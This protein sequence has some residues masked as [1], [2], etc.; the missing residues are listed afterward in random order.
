MR[1]LLLPAA[2]RR[3]LTWV[4]L[5]AGFSVLALALFAPQLGIG[6]KENFLPY[7]LAGI[8]RRQFL[9]IGVF[10]I[11]AVPFFQVLAM[12]KL[13]LDRGIPFLRARL[14]FLGRNVSTAVIPSLARRKGARSGPAGAKYDLR[15][16][17]GADPLQ[18][19]GHCT[20][21]F[22]RR[23]SSSCFA[24]AAMLLFLL[25]IGLLPA[26]STEWRR[27]WLSEV[28]QQYGFVG[29]D[30]QRQAHVI[31]VVA[32]VVFSAISFLLSE[33]AFSA[34]QK[35]RFAPRLRAA[36]CIFLIAL[37]LIVYLFFVPSFIVGW[38]TGVAI[39]FLAIVIAAPRLPAATARH[40]AVAFVGAY[41]M[42]LIVPG[43]LVSP[44]P[45]MAA[46]PVS[47]AQFET[48]L[49]IL[50]M[51]GAAVAAGQNFFNELSI[52][53]GLLM[54]SIMS[55][56]ELKRHGLSIASQLR[57]VQ[58]SQVLFCLA[59]VSAYMA[60]RPRNYVGILAALLLAGPYWAAAGL[61]IWHPNQ[62]GFRSLGLPVGMLTL[63]LAARLPPARA[64]WWLGSVAGAA[65]LMNLE[66]AVAVSIGFAVFLVV[67]TRKLPLTPLLRM[68]GSS[69]MVIVAYLLIY[70]LALGRFPFGMQSLD[71]LSLMER[72]VG[73][74]YG[75]RLFSA[76]HEG[77]GYYLVPFALL[78]FAHAMYVVIDG[79]RELG[80]RA[81]PLRTA[82]RVS[83][84]VTLI[85]WLAYYFNA[86]NWWQIWTEL[87]L[88][89]FL[90]IDLVDRRRFGIGFPSS[91]E[92]LGFRFLTMRI[93]PALLLLLF[94]LAVLIPHTNR[95]LLIYMSDFMFPSWVNNVH[96]ASVLSG[97][98]LPKDK[99]DIL[100]RKATKLKEL[101][102]A[103]G[104][105]MMYLTFNMAFM[106]R[107]TGLFQP[108]PYRDM[109]GEIPGD[110]AFDRLVNDL[111][112]Q[113]PEVILIDAPTGPLAVSGP[114]MDFQD[115]LRRTLS[116]AYRVAETADGW[117]IWRPLDSG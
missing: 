23:Y 90:I 13:T 75:L 51:R 72:F 1:I 40:M 100:E 114:R 11:L 98:L 19:V 93:T 61:G 113:R 78:M 10:L 12:L 41:I 46:D 52:D 71:F 95:H 36:T 25:F 54:P 102:A 107:L 15:A 33:R 17:L 31:T 27:R 16:R 37:G 109:F 34:S 110:A 64:A 117:Q 82:L 92:S 7:K 6:E 65:V 35:L 74:G 20:F 50:P 106:P 5:I 105:R 67:R 28:I 91:R 81:L 3:W 49:L 87:F 60:Y 73:G 44:I 85:V 58:V 94:F 42:V 14:A 83:V 62:T 55:V 59:A 88:Y 2:K 39:L 97:I 101:H 21:D 66:T 4:S 111:L 48:H 86:P 116:P 104:G 89:G 53:Y 76:G 70:P 103:T 9:L 77:E 108:P 45:L 26:D 84:A 8:S 30:D 112:K 38:A 69:A 47:L 32:V 63:V 68:A 56:F 79:F 29:S 99:A 80:R 96:D 22:V 43:L 24:T 18:S 115:R 57:F